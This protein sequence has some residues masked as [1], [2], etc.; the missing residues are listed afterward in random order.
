MAMVA[1][2]VMWPRHYVQT[3]ASPPH[4]GSMC[5][6]VSIGPAASE[7]MFENVDNT[8]VITDI[9]VNENTDYGPLPML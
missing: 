8:D 7:E 6:L 1:I 5:N 9:N 2:L 4:G 3:F